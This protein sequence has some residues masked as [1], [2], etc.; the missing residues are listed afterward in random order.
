MKTSQA[1]RL[2]EFA[3]AAGIELWA[4]PTEESFATL[5]VNGHHEHHR[6]RSVPVRTHLGRLFYEQTQSAPGGQALND[7]LNV[8]DGQARHDGR[9]HDVCVR[10]GGSREAA[11]YL[12]LGDPAWRAV[13]ITPAGWAVVDDPP[14]RF[15]RP[16]G[17]SRLPEPVP[18]GNLE[19]LKELLALG[20][21]EWTLVVSF[22]IAALQPGGSFPVLLIV[23]EQGSGKSFAAGAVRGLIDPATPLL[24]MPPRDERDVAIAAANNH[25]LAYDNLSQIPRLVADVLAVLSTGGGFSKRQLFTDDEEYLVNVKKPLILDGIE[26]PTHRGDLLSRTLRITLPPHDEEEPWRR[27]EHGLQ[28]ELDRLRPRML[29]ALLDAVSA[30]L[31]DRATV[32]LPYKPRMMDAA[33][34]VTAAER[35]LGWPAGT[36]VD[37]WRASR[38]LSGDIQLEG[39]PVGQA[40]LQLFESRST[41]EGPAKDLLT[42]LERVVKDSVVREPT[43]PK[44]PRGLRGQLTRLGPALRLAGFVITLPEDRGRQGHLRTRMLTIVRTVRSIPEGENTG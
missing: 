12:D 18:G 15:R 11:V 44:S 35:Q 1:T 33:M 23:G 7:A 5:R 31:R 36:V 39:D 42:D 32:V 3:Q 40:L 10:L 21:E 29:G 37:A 26:D 41:W 17:Q 13:Q 38:Q 8:L 30:A 25:V 28:R 2:V 16:R 9:Q 20:A 6:L 24:R 34:W 22:L 4:T 14:V 43:W 27:D 19:E